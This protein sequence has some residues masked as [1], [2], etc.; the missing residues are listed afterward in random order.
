MPA[1]LLVLIFSFSSR[2]FAISS[3]S[4][5]FNI[6]ELNHEETFDVYV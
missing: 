3:R 5:R 2:F 6:G 4:L 1:F